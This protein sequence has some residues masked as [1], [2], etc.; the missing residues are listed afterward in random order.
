MVSNLSRRR[1]EGAG[2]YEANDGSAPP[3][4]YKYELGNSGTKICIL[5]LKAFIS[6]NGWEREFHAKNYNPFHNYAAM[7]PN[8]K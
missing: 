7:K 3:L 5:G 4:K 6:R 8:R 2:T 1:V